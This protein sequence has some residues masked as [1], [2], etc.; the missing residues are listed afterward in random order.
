[1]ILA[2][3]T[4]Q[5]PHA[6]IAKTA[7]STERTVPW[8]ASDNLVTDL[9][10]AKQNGA[11]VLAL[12]ITDE[13]QSLLAFKL[14]SASAERP[15]YLIAGNEAAGVSQEL[16]DICDASVHLPMYGQNTSMNVAVALGAAVYLLIGK[17]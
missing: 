8:S 4:P 6:K 7:R 16:L 9:V 5:P 3:K 2:G 15:L 17:L 10:S 12:E 13:S 14:P 11:Y 1:M